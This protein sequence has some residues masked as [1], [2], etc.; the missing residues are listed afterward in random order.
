MNFEERVH[1]F[2]YKLNDTEDQII[3]YIVKNKADV[4][5]LSIQALAARLFTVPNTLTRLSKKLGYDGFSQLKNSLKEELSSNQAGGED[6]LHDNIHRTL[7][8]IDPDKITLVNKMI[9]EASS[10]MF[11][12]VGDSLPFCEMMVKHLRI[13]GKPSEYYV[14]RHEIMHEIM[15]AK[16]NALIF[17]ISLSGETVQVLEM[18]QL[19]KDKGLHSI[20]LTH[21]SRNSLQQL[22]DVNLYCYSPR[23]MLN[24]YNITDK[25]PVMII[26]RV[27]SERFWM[28]T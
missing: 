13:V 17:F 14:H 4:I 12:G 6:K 23:L 10:V 9:Q 8:L 26:I 16:K 15:H 20:S 24:E 27:L 19:S 18:A 21:F 3:E 22:C 11:F 7:K 5:N 2:E 1:Q 28:A 25:T